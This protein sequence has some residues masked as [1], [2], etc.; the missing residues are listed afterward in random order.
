MKRLISSAERR[1][2]RLQHYFRPYTSLTLSLSRGL[3]KPFSL[4]RTEKLKAR[5]RQPRSKPTKNRAAP[6]SVAQVQLE[7]IWRTLQENYFPE[8]KDLL[9]YQVIWSKRRHTATLASCNVY[10]KRVLVASAMN[11]TLSVEH[12]PALIYHEMCHAVLGEP[13]I[14]KGRRVIHGKEFRALERQHPDIPKLN[15]WIKSGSWHQAVRKYEDGK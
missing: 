3:K 10:R 2:I 6:R 8:R 7:T 15:T 5:G 9:D 13:K 1:L 11:Q 12:L 4:Q 14:R